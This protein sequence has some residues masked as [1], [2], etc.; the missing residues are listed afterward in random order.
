MCCSK[1]LTIKRLGPWAV[2][3][4]WRGAGGKQS[5]IFSTFQVPTQKQAGLQFF[6]KTCKNCQKYAFIWI[7]LNWNHIRIS[8]PK[9][10]K[11][12]NVN[13]K[14]IR[15]GSRATTPVWRGAG[16]KQS[17]TYLPSNTKAGSLTNLI[18]NVV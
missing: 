9:S 7:S 3:P 18:K 11:S 2:T 17:L 8:F 4:V 15:R 12:K 10:A 6:L 5:F 16:G 13:L 1:S 14:A